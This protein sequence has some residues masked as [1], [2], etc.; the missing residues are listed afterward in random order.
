MTR[1]LERRDADLLTFR[2]RWGPSPTP[3]DAAPPGDVGAA[4][5][6][7]RARGA[8]AARGPGAGGVVASALQ[9]GTDRWGQ[10]SEGRSE[11]RSGGQRNGAAPPG[12]S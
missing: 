3:S 7:L 10:W 12:E 1:Y 4:G 6:A 11:G 2:E 8:A 9:R 5:V